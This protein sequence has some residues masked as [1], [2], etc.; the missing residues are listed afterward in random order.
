MK[1]KNSRMASRG[2]EREAVEAHEVEEA[3]PLIEE[4]EVVSLD[5]DRVVE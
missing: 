2:K 1:K 3:C 5:L 4:E